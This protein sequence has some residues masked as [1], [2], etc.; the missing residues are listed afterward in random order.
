MGLQKF[1]ADKFDKQS[2]GAEIGVSEWLGG[3]TVSLVRNCRLANL[4][5]NMRRTVYATGDPDTFF[6]IPAV[7]VIAGCHVNGHLTLDED[8]LTVFRQCYY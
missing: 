5:G 4:E 1:R 8:C 7:T 3:P 2:D 6:S